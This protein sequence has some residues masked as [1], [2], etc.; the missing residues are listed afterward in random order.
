MITQQPTIS[1]SAWEEI[2]DGIYR[3]MP[4]LTRKGVEQITLSPRF[5]V[6]LEPNRDNEPVEQNT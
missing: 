5:Q 2:I 1:V 3:S 4:E 6:R